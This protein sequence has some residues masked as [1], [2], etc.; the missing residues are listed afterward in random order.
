[1]FKHLM[2]LSIKYLSIKYICSNKQTFAFSK[3]SVFDHQCKVIEQ[4]DYVA[5]YI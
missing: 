1:M 2:D 4:K 3:N 5:C